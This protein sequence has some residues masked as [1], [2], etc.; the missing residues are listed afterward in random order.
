MLG[1]LE[2]VEGAEREPPR[3]LCMQE[4]CPLG[5]ERDAV[6]ETR[7]WGGDYGEE[8]VELQSTD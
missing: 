4:V 5:L 1:I 2:G 6:L 8:T 3:T 7:L